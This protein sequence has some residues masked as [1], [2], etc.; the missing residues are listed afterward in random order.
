MEGV[1]NWHEA[2]GFYTRIN[3]RL[4]GIAL[5]YL[6]TAEKISEI[7]KIKWIDEGLDRFSNKMRMKDVGGAVYQ[8]SEFLHENSIL[9]LA[10]VVE[11]TSIELKRFVGFK[12]DLIDKHY[13]VL[14][15]RELQS[16]RALANVIKHNVSI[17]DRKS[18]VSARFLVD[19][20]GM[21]DGWQLDVFIHTRHEVFNVVEHIPKTYLAMLHLTEISLG[22]RHPYLDMAYDDAF[23]AIY[24]F[25]LPEVINISRPNKRKS[26]G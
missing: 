8:F 3:E 5:S 10:K 6:A 1:D 7:S 2:M 23:D 21:S 11:D 22:E 12:F 24:E 16:I 25:L 4:S 13:D 14:Y 15:Q 17:L 18:S 26:E 19:E 20:I 9:A